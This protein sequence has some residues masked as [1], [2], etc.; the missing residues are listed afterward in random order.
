METFS[1][2]ENIS[3]HH[4]D[5]YHFFLARQKQSKPQVARIK[6]VEIQKYFFFFVIPRIG[7]AHD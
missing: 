2:G 4:R 1:F 6:E 5:E 7:L 3:Y